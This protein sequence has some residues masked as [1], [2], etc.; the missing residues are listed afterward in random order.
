MKIKIDK[1]VDLYDKQFK[2]REWGIWNFICSYHDGGWGRY[3]EVECQCCGDH[4]CIRLNDLYLHPTCK[5]CS[6][7]EYLDG[8]L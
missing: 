1:F 3:F 8:N 6:A 2:N 5:L 7:K 4:A